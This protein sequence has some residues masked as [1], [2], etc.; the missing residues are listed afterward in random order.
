MFQRWLGDRRPGAAGFLPSAGMCLLGG[1]PTATSS[2]ASSQQLLLTAGF[3]AVQ[4]GSQLAVRW[5]V[6]RRYLKPTR[7][8]GRPTCGSGMWMKAREGTRGKA[9]ACS[10]THATV[11]ADTQPLQGSSAV[12]GALAEWSLLWREPV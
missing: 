4:R 12:L 11:P 6:I 7:P 10:S 3:A 8:T 1:P 9:A 2:D 5:G